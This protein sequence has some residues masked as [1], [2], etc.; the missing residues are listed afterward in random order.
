MRDW[1]NADNREEAH[2]CDCAVR[3]GQASD[4]IADRMLFVV[5]RPERGTSGRAVWFVG[6]ERNRAVAPLCCRE[7]KGLDGLF[8][9]VGAGIVCSENRT[10]SHL[11]DNGRGWGN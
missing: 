5:V 1:R 11:Y 9:A 4:R 8:F 2:I 7:A 3:L 10:R 6:A